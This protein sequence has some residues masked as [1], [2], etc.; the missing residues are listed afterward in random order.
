MSVL[1]AVQVI[2]RCCK[3]RLHLAGWTRFEICTSK[4]IPCQAWRRWKTWN[5]KTQSNTIVV[6]SWN[7]NFILTASYKHQVINRDHSWWIWRFFRFVICISMST[8]GMITFAN[9]GLRSSAA[10]LLTW[11]CIHSLDRNSCNRSTMARLAIWELISAT[12]IYLINPHK[13][14]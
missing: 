10:W 2:P 4:I 1:A 6:E 13:S 7:F 12:S 11:T 14:T 5:R 9:Q 3:T 8:A